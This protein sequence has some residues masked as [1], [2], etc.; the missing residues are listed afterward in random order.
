MS[1]NHQPDL[2]YTEGLEAGR[3]IVGQN[4]PEKMLIVWGTNIIV[5]DVVTAFRDFLEN[6]TLAH[7]P[8]TDSASM[9]AESAMDRIEPFY[10][11]LL[12][13]LYTI[14]SKYLLILT[15]RFLN[16]DG[17]NL[18]SYHPTRLLFDQL[19][20]HPQEM[21]PIMDMTVNEYF[22]ELFPDVGDI[23]NNPIQVHI[24]ILE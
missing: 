2:G 21:I 13:Y 7:L 22:M 12:S 19:L 6:F 15:R 3:N 18:R 16:I 5:K 4:P 10:P 17:R 20:A 24:T 11:R 8:D 1:E 14:E 9:T 23:I